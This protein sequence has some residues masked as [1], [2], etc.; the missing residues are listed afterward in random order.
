MSDKPSWMPSDFEFV[1]AL[2]EAERMGL[3]RMDPNDPELLEPLRILIYKV[4]KKALS[5]Q[6][7][8]LRQQHIDDLAY[9]GTHLP[10]Q[11]NHTLKCSLCQRLAVLRYELAGLTTTSEPMGPGQPA[12]DDIGPYPGPNP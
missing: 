10:T 2:E 5:E 7:S 4:A 3:E 6:E 9:W 1:T 11:H 12:P 8:R